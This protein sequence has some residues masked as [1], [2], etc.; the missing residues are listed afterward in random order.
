MYS[1]YSAPLRRP[2]GRLWRRDP[3][4]LLVALMGSVAALIVM[5]GSAYGST[6]SG[7]V[8]VRVKPGDTVWSI[9]ASHYPGD[10]TRQRVEDIESLNHLPGAFV[11]PGQELALPQ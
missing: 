3:R 5:S 2:R 6:A 1:D 7:P 11:S 8:T 9:A 4:S 10:D